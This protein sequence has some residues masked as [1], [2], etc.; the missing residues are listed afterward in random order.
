MPPTIGAA[1]RRITSDPVPEPNMI[2]SSPRDDHGDR[3]RDRPHAQRCAR[4]DSLRETRLSSN[5]PAASRAATG[6][7]DVD[8]HDNADFGRHGERDEADRRC[9]R[10]VVA[11]HDISQNPRRVQKAASMSKAS[12]TRRNAK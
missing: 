8:E 2:G 5:R 11:Q 4:D 6:L 1:I 7:V 10:H 9:D 3:H 12:A